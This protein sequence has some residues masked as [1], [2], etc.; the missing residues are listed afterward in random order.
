MKKIQPY[1]LGSGAASKAIQK[2]IAALKI[3]YPQWGIQDP[4][5]LKRGT[6]LSSL[7]EDEVSKESVLILANPH[8]LHAPQVLKAQQAGFQWV[9]TEKPA[10]VSL[11]QVEILKDISIPVAVFHGYRQ[12]WAIQTLKK[13]LDQGELGN[14]Q[15]IEGRY[16]QSSATISAGSPKTWKDDPK[17]SGSFDVLLD[18]G[19]HFTDLVFFLAGEPADSTH[20]WKSFINASS[21]HRD[22]YNH[23]S[24][25]FSQNKR[26]FGSVSKTVHGAG[27]DLELHVVGEKKSVSWKLSQPDELIVAEGT[28]AC[29]LSRPSGSSFGSEQYPFH[30]MGWLEGYI[31]ILK[32]YFLQMRQEPY[33]S[34]PNLKDQINVLRALFS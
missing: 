2:S 32:Q 6:D 21:S 12:T 28:K 7:I 15:T 14:W 25:V 3:Q 33:Q 8:A 34:Y 4:V 20:V 26:A 1:L 29:T 18:L 10:A 31:E 13:M 16:W 30:G 5:L 17:L 22:T 23:L 19:T 11:E 27:N 24:F 9:V